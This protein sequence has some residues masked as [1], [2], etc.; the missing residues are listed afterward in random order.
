MMLEEKI[1]QAQYTILEALDRCRNPYIALSGGKDSLVVAHLV[2]QV[3]PDVQMVYCDDE[4]L[5]PEHV[6]YMR[7]VK[8]REGARLRM[9]SGG[10]VHRGW[11]R[12]WGD[13]SLWWR[14][15]EPEMEWLPRVDRHMGQLSKLAPYLGYDGAFLG[16]RRAESIR[17]AN[18]LEAASGIDWVKGYW[19]VNPL[20]D[21][22][23][24]DVWEYIDEC[25]LAYCP[26]YDRL[27]EI[28]VGRHHAR[29]G[30]LPLSDGKHLWRGWPQLYAALVRH[31][32]QRWTVPVGPRCP[33]GVAM[34]DWLDIQDALRG[35]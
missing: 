11:F 8:D 18:I 5:Y 30:P 33:K 20:I 6:A 7:Q 34:L 10:G 31:Y 14:E 27:T 25:E 16:L 26:V 4:L 15:P 9:V 32:G 21:W 24:A 17:R 28:G 19:H 22:S 29:V 2:H 1:E 3:K 23:D 13:D 12:P 35:A